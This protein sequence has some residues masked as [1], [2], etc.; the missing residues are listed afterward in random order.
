[1][2]AA[3]LEPDVRLDAGTRTLHADFAIRNDSP[4]TWRPAEGFGVGYHLFDADTGTLI[5]DGARVHP[6]HDVKPGE[7]AQVRLEIPTAA[8]RRPLPGAALADA[9]KRLLVLRAGLAVPA[10][11]D[12]HRERRGARGSRARGH[13]RHARPRAR[14]ARHRPRLRLSGIDD[15]A[16]SRPDPRDGAARHSGTLS[17]QLR[18][19]V[20]DHHQS[21]AAD[22]H[23][24]FRL[25]RGAARPLRSARQPGGASRSTSWRACCRGWRSARPPGARRA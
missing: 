11:G 8:R 3:Y 9:R 15:L 12:V 7:T 19:R 22:A 6:E 21:A 24:L 13:P 16:Q 10:G 14:G 17:R 25:R 2:N 4:E 23:V 5:V 1:M 18:R 20:L